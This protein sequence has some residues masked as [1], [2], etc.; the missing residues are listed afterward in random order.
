MNTFKIKIQN[1]E[2]L[3]A[4]PASKL[5]SLCHRFDSNIMLIFADIKVNGNHTIIVNLSKSIPCKISKGKP[6]LATNHH[7]N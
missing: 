7:A 3:H 6:N 4:R 2:G 5:V 1:S